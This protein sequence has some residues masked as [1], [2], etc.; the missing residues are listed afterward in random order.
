[1]KFTF[2]ARGTSGYRAP[3]LLVGENGGFN[4]KVDIWALGCILHEL[5]TWE[6]PFSSDGQVVKYAESKLPLDIKLSQDFSERSRASI[7]STIRDMLQIEPSSRP[8]ALQLYDQFCIFY[9]RV[10]D[11]G[12]DNTSEPTTP[13]TYICCPAA[14]L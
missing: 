8:S 3:E 4:N 6:R 9:Q 10:P 1:M 7:S 12:F 2:M 14:D 11:G 13:S 5:V